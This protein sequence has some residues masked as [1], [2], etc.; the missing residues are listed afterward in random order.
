MEIKFEKDDLIPEQLET[1]PK[2]LSDSISNNLISKK[3][4]FCNPLLSDEDKQV[5]FKNA[6]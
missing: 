6:F 1:L 5:V 3:S 4:N 2:I